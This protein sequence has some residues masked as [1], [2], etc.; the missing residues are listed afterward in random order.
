MKRTLALLTV[1][2]LS[3]PAS[4][5]EDARPTAEQLRFFES[6]VRPVLA[7][8]CQRCHGSQKQNGGL[9]LDSAEALRKGGDTGP[10]VEPGKPAESLLLRAVNHEGELKM[11]PKEKLK[12]DEIAA[13]TEWVRMGA[14]WPE[15]RV[16]RPTAD[17]ARTYWAFQ[18]VKGPP[19]P[20]VK[21]EAWPRNDVDRFVLAALE[22]RGLKPVGPADKRTLIRRLTF[23]LTGLP[24][25]PEEIDAFLA[26]ESP[27][28]YR[29]VVDRLLA[30]PHYGE[31]WGRHWL[32]V[33]RYADTAGDNSDYPVPQLYKYRNWVLRAFNE[34]KPYDE[35]LREQ[36]AGDLMPGGTEQETFDR[37]VA[38]G[39]LANSRRFGSYEDA[40]YQWYLTYEDTIDNLGRTVLGLSLSCA[41]CHDHKFD[42]IPTDDYYALYGFFQSTRY[43]WPGTELA[44]V[45]YDLV[46]LVPPDVAAAAEKERA[47]QLAT[48]DAKVK[49]LEGEKAAADKAAK[50]SPDA[51]PRADEAAKALQA[52]KKERDL[53]AKKPLRIE[54]AYAMADGKTQGKKIV[55]NAKVH[56]RGDPEKLGTEVPRRFLTALGG[57]PLPPAVRGSGRMELANWLTD[58]KNPLTARVM[59]NRVWHYHFGKGVVPTPS[60]F[61]KQ[62][63]PPT[64][65][66]LLD[67]LASRFVE[68]GWSVKA[69]HRLLLLSATYQL[70][71][72]DDEPNAQTDPNNDG[73]WKYS[74]RRLDAESVRDA[75]LAVGG[76]LDLSPGGPHPFPDQT[77]WDYTQH[78]PFKAVY[79]TNRR[80]PDRPG[81]HGP[82][83]DTAG[84]QRGGGQPPCDRR[85]QRR[86]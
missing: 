82:V 8:N 34:D 37:L 59:A 58:P 64:N 27:G 12:P 32:D 60:D 26:D 35:F 33:V 17:D 72:A 48:L 43:P 69:M 9:R 86:V 10:V 25:A 77:T 83:R 2:S 16:A 63:Q 31:R 13:L 22:S 29:T 28:A 84:R 61:G 7:N 5:A 49:R 44:K 3:A 81:H 39:Y 70:A 47:E 38:T 30:S 40:R 6:K 51:K 68:S 53:F 57:E 18:P 36:I 11:P 23:D 76:G 62:G 42:P 20:R 67:Y 45:P 24:P 78:K 55:G 79:D 65:P 85:P 56:L 19:A 74:R 54:T 73:F 52:A 15:T 80:H 71:G 4:A 21:D 1:L 75:L 41:R 66:E 46:P 14:P 50:E